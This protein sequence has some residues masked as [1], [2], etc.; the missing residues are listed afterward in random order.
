M[1]RSKHRQQ[2]LSDFFA[3]EPFKLRPASEDASFRSYYRITT[4]QQSYILMDAPP[5]HEDCKPFIKVLK[6]LQQS[7][8][9]VPQLF[10]E[11]LQQGFLL[12]A[13]FGNTLYLD[14]L[15]EDTVDE[16]YG[17]AIKS[18]INIQN[19]PA[20]DLLP[21]YD[22]ELL[23]NE[24]QLFED[25]FIQKHLAVTLNET[26][27][28]VI[29]NTFELLK[30]NAIEQPQAMVHRDFHSR[31]LMVTSSHS[32]GVIDFQDAVHG[33]YTYDLVSLLK[34]CYISWPDEKVH[35]ICEVFKNQSNHHT[36]E[37]SDEQFM[38]WFDLMGAQRH[39]KAIGIFCRLHYR[40]GK[41][42]YLNDIP[43]TMRYLLKT[44]KK[45]PDLAAFAQLLDD[46]QPK[47][48]SAQ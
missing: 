33:P 19:T 38:R 9:N 28:K 15:K 12:L 6:L 35:A 8:V 36:A 13:D 18:L 37:I 3:G 29:K 42:G 21:Q 32:P 46:I 14:A 5:A 39:L 23:L 45:H 48:A 16:L 25:W 43:R 30:N 10:A 26:Q 22:S 34:D 11:D 1:K 40:D 41:S 20:A 44:A 27:K 2:W 7:H 47:L 31:N 24:M 17:A 4:A